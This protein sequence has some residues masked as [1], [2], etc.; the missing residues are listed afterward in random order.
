MRCGWDVDFEGIAKSEEVLIA[1]DGVMLVGQS[2]RVSD[3]CRML[4]VEGERFCARH[5]TSKVQGR[6]EGAEP[7]S[8]F[9]NVQTSRQRPVRSLAWV[10]IL[11]FSAV[12]AN[13]RNTHISGLN[14]SRTY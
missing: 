8:S 1:T 13:H 12:V 10:G 3:T 9:E 11:Y 7:E 6:G 4:D 5:C 2:Y 14:W